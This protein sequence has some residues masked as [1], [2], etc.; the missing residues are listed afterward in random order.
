MRKVTH[1]VVRHDGGWAYQA[2][3]GHSEPFR[4][5]REARTAAKLAA[6]EQATAAGSAEITY[7][8]ER[9]RWH[10]KVDGGRAQ[11]STTPEPKATQGSTD[12][13]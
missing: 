1:K 6:S 5:R 3:G 10:D 12:R 11:D 7:E 9:E 4:T 8:T 13:A 2:N